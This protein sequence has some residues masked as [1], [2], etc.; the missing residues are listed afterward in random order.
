MLRP[1]LDTGSPSTGGP[2]ADTLQPCFGDALIVV[3]LQ[4]DFLAGGSLAVPGGDRVLG[5]VNRWLALFEQRGLP[6][7]AVRDWHPA[8]HCSFRERGGPWPAHCVAGTPGAAFASGLRLPARPRLVSKGTRADRDAQS[9]FAGTDLEP[10]LVAAQ[11]RRLYL[12]GLATDRCILQTAQEARRRRF[13]VVVP[14]DAV[15]AFDADPGDGER[16]LERMQALGASVVD[17]DLLLR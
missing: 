4:R 2:I 6:T 11:I 17:S 3:D 12:A 15:A 7:F 10:R 13:G 5:P 1:S 8:D 9:C 16:A 14:R